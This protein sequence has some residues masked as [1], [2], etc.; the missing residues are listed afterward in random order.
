MA[1]PSPDSRQR[2][3]DA[4]LK[5]FANRGYA[6]TAVQDIVQEAR[7]TKPALYYYFQ[8]KEGLFQALVDQAMDDRLRLMRQ[9]APPEKETVAQMVDI[10]L[11]VSAYSARQPD[12]MRLCFSIGFAAPGEIPAGLRK[13][14]KMGRVLSF[15]SGH[16][17]TRARARRPGFVV[18]RR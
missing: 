11:A 18:Q 14:G 10:L 15:R 4:G 16:H 6:G 7:V 1:K 9:A 17:R 8:N 5:L 3:L 2:L 12:L 13:R